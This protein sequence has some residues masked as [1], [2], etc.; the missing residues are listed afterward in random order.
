MKGVNIKTIK[1][2][3]A[4]F[5]LNFPIFVFTEHLY[6]TFIFVLFLHLFVVF[7]HTMLKF[8]SNYQVVPVLMLFCENLSQES[9]FIS[10]YG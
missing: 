5:R 7:L 1:K 6:D 4:Q 3:F 10:D 9:F 2:I 8:Y